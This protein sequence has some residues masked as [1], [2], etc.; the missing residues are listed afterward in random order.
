[1][2]NQNDLATVVLAHLRAQP[3]GAQLTLTLSVDAT[4][5]AIEQGAGGAGGPEL[6]S[7]AWCAKNIGYSSR[8][9]RQW[10]E[11]DKIAGAMKDAGGRWRLPI[12]TAREHLERM[13]H[14]DQ[15]APA[16]PRLV[17]EEGSSSSTRPRRKRGGWKK[18]ALAGGDA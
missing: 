16:G 5:V 6:V 9:W 12:K 13:L 10:C 3:K 2:I 11:D 4:I 1:M 15:P 14:P 8:M 17:E 18:K 7:T